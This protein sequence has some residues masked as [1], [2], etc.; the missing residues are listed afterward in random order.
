MRTR[1]RRVVAGLAVLVAL[2]LSACSAGAGGPTTS[3]GATLRVANLTTA[4]YL[5]I[6]GGGDLLTR[7]TAAEG[8]SAE[9]VGPFVPTDALAAVNAGQADVT[10]TGTASFD[11]LL[12]KGSD[13]VAF[14]I[15]RYS[16]NSQGIVAAP[17]SGVTGLKDL[18]GKKIA[19]GQEGGTGHW[20]LHRAFEDAGLDITKVEI[21]YLLPK[22]AA[23]AFT[24]GQVDAWST[25][26]QYLATAQ[27]V[28]GAR[29]LV[30]GDRLD[31]LNWTI[32]IASRQIA[33]THPELL[34]AAY[35]ALR[36][37]ATAAA[38][39]PQVILDT[40]RGFGATEEQI[41]R[42]ATFSVPTIEP[43]D[44]AQ[45]T[46]LTRLAEQLTRYGLIE[47]APDISGHVFDA[48]APA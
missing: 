5:T 3:S 44:D 2:V 12:S 27:A 33:E 43:V 18:Y 19:V 11:T 46:N 42:I 23:T 35:R 20:L 39:D 34:R 29:T 26:D 28:D 36:A 17:G 22:D 25:F 13:Y 8:G 6:V 10:S 21:V 31:S 16:G 15:E 45:V 30:T 38:A 47:D 1:L 14:A 41:S 9:F 32:H 37:Q 48:A 7:E 40:Y 4:N 24:T